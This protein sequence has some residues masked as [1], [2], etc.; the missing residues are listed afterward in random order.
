MYAKMNENNFSLCETDINIWRLY[1]FVFPAKTIKTQ[2]LPWIWFS[3]C[4]HVPRSVNIIEIFQIFLYNWN[5]F[6]STHCY[7]ISI[8]W[9]LLFY[10]KWLFNLPYLA[11]QVNSKHL[12]SFCEFYYSCY[13]L[14]IG[15]SLCTFGEH[16]WMSLQC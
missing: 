5:E 11:S 8:Y 2:N 14:Q 13:T 7:V 10:S 1:A 12:K 3:M 15:F 16:S 6:I 4:S 9:I